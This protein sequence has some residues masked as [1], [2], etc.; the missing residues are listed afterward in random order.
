M[1][2]GEILVVSTG[3]LIDI[4]R[5]V[6]ECWLQNPFLDDDVSGICLRIGADLADVSDAVDRLCQAGLL[7]PAAGGGFAL[8]VDLGGAVLSED[9]T[10]PT[11]SP[12]YDDVTDIVDPDEGVAEETAHTEV[13]PADTAH[14]AL[15][16][17]SGALQTEADDGIDE[18]AVLDLLPSANRLEDLAREI[19]ATLSALVPDQE[20]GEAD[21]LDVLPFGVIVLH[22]S[23]ALEL[24][25]L[26]AG[27]LLDVP[28]EHLD[29]ASFEMATGVNP[30]SVLAAETSLSFSLTEP[31][32]LEITLQPHRLA[33]GEVILI[34]LRDVALLEEVS[35]MQADVQEELYGQMREQMVDPLSMI[36]AF[37]E[38]PDTTGLVEARFAME[39]INAFL[40]NHYLSRRD[41]QEGQ[42][43]EPC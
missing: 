8:T 26:E 34:F 20:V 33:A 21:L 11:Q 16:S 35:R 15:A 13:D 37:L 41:S 40:R 6:L 1:R 10:F 23:G 30:L 18:D 36:E 12:V 31:Q 42:G 14:A 29:G 38:K 22:P 25:N 4:R 3:L 7:R 28:I 2:E 32:P 27:R 24:A 19:A 9:L 5:Q 43:P 17:L 39:Q